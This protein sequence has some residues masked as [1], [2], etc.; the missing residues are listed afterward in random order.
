MSEHRSAALVKGHDGDPV[1]VLGLRVY[2]EDTDFSGRVY[3][4]SYLRYLERGRTEWLRDRGFVQAD[5]FS[6]SALAFVVR[7]L[8]IE[9]RHSAAMDDWLEVVTSLKE[10]RR[11]SV[12]FSQSI[13]RGSLT[14]VTAEVLAAAVVN[15]RV[16]RLPSFVRQFS[17]S[18]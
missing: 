17:A 13:H 3:H 12:V 1:N 15:G 10:K 9:Y 8:S 4:G 6:A 5:V 7:C 18:L 14:L 11:A 16:T 2:Y